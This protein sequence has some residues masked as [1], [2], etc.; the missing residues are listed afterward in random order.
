[1]K[2]CTN[3]ITANL[4]KISEEFNSYFSSVDTKTVNEI[5]TSYNSYIYFLYKLI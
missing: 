4:I 2:G 3:L 5:I 1:M